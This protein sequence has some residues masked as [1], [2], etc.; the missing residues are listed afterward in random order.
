MK[1]CNIQK[2]KKKSNFNS[3]YMLFLMLIRTINNVNTKYILKFRKI[4][5]Q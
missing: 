4:N 1:Y 5:Q 2:G 3:T